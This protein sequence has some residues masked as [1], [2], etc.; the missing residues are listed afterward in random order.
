MYSFERSTRLDSIQLLACFFIYLLEFLQAFP[1]TLF[2]FSEA[3]EMHRQMQRP[4]MYNRPN[5]PIKVRFE[6]NM[7]TE[8]AVGC[9]IHDPTFDQFSLLTFLCNY[10]ILF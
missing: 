7:N 3:L 5:A 10:Y 8:K 2:M 1:L 4:E 9:S 6:L